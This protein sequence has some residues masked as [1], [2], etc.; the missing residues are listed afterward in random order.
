LELL[1]WWLPSVAK[2]LKDRKGR[3]MDNPPQYCRIITAIAKTIEIQ[4][5][6]DEDYSNVESQLI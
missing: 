1:Y 2:F 6:I 4:Q 3:T 5:Q